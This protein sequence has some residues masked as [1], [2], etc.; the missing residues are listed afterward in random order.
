MFDLDLGYAQDFCGEFS[1]KFICRHD[2]C[3]ED[4]LHEPGARCILRT[5]RPCRTR[6]KRHAHQPWRAQSVDALQDAV[7]NAVSVAE[8]RS[9][10]MILHEVRNDYGSCLDRSVHRHLRVLCNEHKIIR[11]EWRRVYAYLR[12]GSKMIAEPGLVFEQILSARMA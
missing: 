11:L 5:L 8:P 9:F 3:E 2:G 1:P 7:F 6:S 10:Q 4:E 12:N